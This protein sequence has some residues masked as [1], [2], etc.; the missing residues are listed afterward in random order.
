MIIVFCLI[1]QDDH[2][3]LLA[4]H[5]GQVRHGGLHVIWGQGVV[6]GDAEDQENQYHFGKEF[7]RGNF[8]IAAIKRKSRVCT[9]ENLKSTSDHWSSD[10]KKIILLDMNFTT[11]KF[12]M[13]G[14][15]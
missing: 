14:L 11:T 5:V 2:R 9:T 6:A 15:H 10:L 7:N 1:L 3:I 13:H 8:C 12:E 4:H